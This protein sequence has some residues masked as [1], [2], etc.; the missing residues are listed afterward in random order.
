MYLLKEHHLVDYGTK[1]ML[2]GLSPNLCRY[3]KISTNLLL[4]LFLEAT[5]PMVCDQTI[6]S[7]NFFIV[8]LLRKT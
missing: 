7:Y 2:F 8:F 3:K 6:A 5:F 1:N 4:I